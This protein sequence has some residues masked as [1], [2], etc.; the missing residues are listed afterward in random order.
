MRERGVYPD[1]KRVGNTFTRKRAKASTG[2]F[3][4]DCRALIACPRRLTGWIVLI[5]LGGGS[6]CKVFDEV[7]RVFFGDSGLKAMDGRTSAGEDEARGLCSSSINEP[8]SAA[9]ANSED[10]LLLRESSAESSSMVSAKLRD[11]SRSSSLCFSVSKLLAFA[12]LLGLICLRLKT[13][14]SSSFSDD[15]SLLVAVSLLARCFT[16]STA[17]R[18]PLRSR[19][20]PD[21]REGEVIKT[22]T[23]SLVFEPRNGDDPDLSRMGILANLICCA[24]LCHLATI[25][26]GATVKPTAAC[27][28]RL[29]RSRR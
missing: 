18:E 15:I 9:S 7:L 25:I 26:V 22:S 17:P 5:G 24:A 21:R 12:V 10:R 19:P 28:Q 1:I 11:G 20:S 23:S 13:D 8:E 6:A 14:G 16:A 4:F 2:F 3:G 27:P 29:H